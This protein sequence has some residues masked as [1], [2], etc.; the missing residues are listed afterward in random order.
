MLREVKVEIIEL[1]TN[2]TFAR[3]LSLS[4]AVTIFS[5]CGLAEL[6]S[7]KTLL[8]QQNSITHVSNSSSTKVII[9]CK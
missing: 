1:I 8:T 6:Q 3:N 2:L 4:M 5:L 7:Q 9:E